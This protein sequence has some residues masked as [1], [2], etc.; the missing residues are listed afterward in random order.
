MTNI[1]KLKIVK[2]LKIPKNFITSESTI[3]DF[4]NK[5]HPV[6]DLSGTITKRSIAV[7][8]A[9]DMLKNYFDKRDYL[10][11]RKKSSNLLRSFVS[12]MVRETLDLESQKLKTL[13]S[14]YRDL[15]T[16]VIEKTVKN[17]KLNSSFEKIILS[18]R[19]YNNLGENDYINFTILTRDLEEIAKMFIKSND[20]FKKLKLYITDDNIYGNKMQIEDG[21]LYGIPKIDVKTTN[22]FEKLKDMEKKYEGMNIIYFSDN[23]KIKSLEKIEYFIKIK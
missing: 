1:N 7:N 14:V 17:I 11:L 19:D 13:F 22:K 8:L 18:I 21:K 12:Y 16:H 23:E 10:N 15:D 2:N 6:S 4:I 9:F 5:A 3:D 20:S